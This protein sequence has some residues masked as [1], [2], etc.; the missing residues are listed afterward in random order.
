MLPSW[1]GQ[2]HHYPSVNIPVSPS[3]GWRYSHFSYSA[4]PDVAHPPVPEVL[5]AIKEFWPD[6]CYFGMR[7]IWKCGNRHHTFFAHC[8]GSHVWNPTVD[9]VK[10]RVTLPD[11]YT[12]P[13]PTQID[14]QLSLQEHWYDNPDLPKMYAPLDWRVFHY[15]RTVYD[16]H[17]S[18]KELEVRYIKNMLEREE[19]NREAAL[20]A[21]NEMYLPLDAYMEKKLAEFSDVEIADFYRKYRVLR[22][23]QEEELQAKLQRAEESK[24]LRLFISRGDN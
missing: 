17:A 12:G 15:V 19:K 22:H 18:S 7:Q 9:H 8:L 5:E 11:N 14:M 1:V 4:I 10:F 2:S 16:P 20:Q 21:Y 6:V 24:P 13:I 23:E 3:E